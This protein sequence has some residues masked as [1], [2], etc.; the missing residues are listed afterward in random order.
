MSKWF[1]VHVRTGH[2]EKIKKLIESKLSNTGNKTVKQVIV[3]TEDVA[4]T[5]KGEKTVKK[6]KF[7]PGYLIVETEDNVDDATWYLIKTTNGV[8][9]VLGAGTK[10]AP[11]GA[12]EADNLKQTIEER[13]TKPVPKIEF[14]KGDKVEI[15]DG[16]FVN[17]TGIVEDINNEKERLKISVSIFG[18]STILE[19]NFWQVEKV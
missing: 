8:F 14:N 1:I 10:P 19:L 15:I 2:E 12:K 9:K 16:P 7:F 5:L 17:F 4:E 18:R 11:L 13:K 6:R 3:P